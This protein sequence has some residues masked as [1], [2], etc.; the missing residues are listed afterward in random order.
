MYYCMF[1]RKFIRFLLN[2]LSNI[3]QYISI[4]DSC[5]LRNSCYRHRGSE[6]SQVSIWLLSDPVHVFNISFS[7]TLL[8]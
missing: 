6:L 4:V 5:I 8:L 2:I 7:G 1:V 3:L